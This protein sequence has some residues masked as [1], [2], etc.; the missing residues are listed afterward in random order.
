MHAA[1]DDLARLNYTGKVIGKQRVITIIYNGLFGFKS[2]TTELTGAPDTC[3]ST[4]P[5]RLGGLI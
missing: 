4:A 1:G 5:D 3:S 2:T